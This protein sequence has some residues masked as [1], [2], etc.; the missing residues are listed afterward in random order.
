MARANRLAGRW[1]AEHTIGAVILACIPSVVAG[2]I[3]VFARLFNVSLDRVFLLV[4]VLTF[5][6]GL[7]IIFVLFIR[8]IVNYGETD[9][10]WRAGIG[11]T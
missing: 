7:M 6:S 5:A 2:I 3:G 1:I 9:D 8:H 11:A 4:G 10:R